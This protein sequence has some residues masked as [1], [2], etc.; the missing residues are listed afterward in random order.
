MIAWTLVF[1]VIGLVFWIGS[2]L[3]VTHVLA[4]HLDETSAEARATLS[5]LELR[6]LRGFAHPGAAIVVL[7]GILLVSRDPHFL[8]AYWLQ[9]KMVLVAGLVGLDLRVTFCARGFQEGSV[10]LTRRECTALHGAIALVFFGIV[11][12]ALVRPFGIMRAH[13]QI[14]AP[15]EKALTVVPTLA[16]NLQALA[17]RIINR[18]TRV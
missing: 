3:A 5:R 13:A 9:A 2:L 7:S 4:I 1:H 12:L 17:R 14:A 6:L 11:I 18:Q 15:S 8:R 10:K 16:N